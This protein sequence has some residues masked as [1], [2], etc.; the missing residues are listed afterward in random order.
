MNGCTPD[1][2]TLTKKVPGTC[3]G[4]IPDWRGTHTEVLKFNPEKYKFCISLNKRGSTDLWQS[5]STI[6]SAGVQPCKTGVQ[7]GRVRKYWIRCK[8][9]G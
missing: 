2:C 1:K 4:M 7:T 8:Y 9:I 5:E 3:Q 6:T